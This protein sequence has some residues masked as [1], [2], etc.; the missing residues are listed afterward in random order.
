[1]LTIARKNIFLLIYRR[2][3]SVKTFLKCVDNFYHRITEWLRPAGTL[4][5]IEFHPPPTGRAAQHRSG[6]SRPI[7]HGLES[8]QGCSIHSVSGQPLSAKHTILDSNAKWEHYVNTTGRAV[9]IYSSAKCKKLMFLLR[10]PRAAY[11]ML[12]SLLNH[13]S[14]R[15]HLISF[16]EC[17]LLLRQHP[18]FMLW[19]SD[20]YTDAIQSS[21]SSSHVFWLYLTGQHMLYYWALCFP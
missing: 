18:A 3:P 15:V 7:H 21:F 8:L 16:S 10:H 12:P 4:K 1:M 11:W 2:I 20:A 19:I 14:I 6:C 17:R 9:A 5:I 13:A